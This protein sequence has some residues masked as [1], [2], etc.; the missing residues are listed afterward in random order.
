[1]ESGEIFIWKNPEDKSI[2]VIKFG[3]H[4][5]NDSVNS[6]KFGIWYLNAIVWEL[7][8][9]KSQ[10]NRYCDKAASL[11]DKCDFMVFARLVT[12][13]I[14]LVIGTSSFSLTGAIIPCRNTSL[15]CGGK[16]YGFWCFG[17]ASDFKISLCWTA[18]V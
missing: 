18:V 10:T 5:E 8:H 2:E 11:S 1:V 14:G 7:S 13:T 17:F 4:C 3:V 6:S 15:L 16:R 12:S 9:R